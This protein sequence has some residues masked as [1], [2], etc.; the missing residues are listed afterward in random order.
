MD[1]ITQAV[2]SWENKGTTYTSLLLLLLFTLY[3][4]DVSN[5]K[6]VTH[7][8]M[9]YFES[10]TDAIVL[11]YIFPQHVECEA[12]IIAI[13]AWN[14]FFCPR[15]SA[16]QMRAH[17]GKISPTST[18][19]LVPRWSDKLLRLRL[20]YMAYALTWTYH[21]PVVIIDIH[22]FSRWNP[23]SFE[24]VPPQPRSAD[25]LTKRVLDRL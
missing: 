17:Q 5:K 9:Y 24:L 19:A 8:L 15:K 20:V 4:M 21:C 3:T 2:R 1:I 12:S 10:N 11:A 7:N 14:I 25:Q 22:P 23:S 16:I 6:S 13:A 18:T